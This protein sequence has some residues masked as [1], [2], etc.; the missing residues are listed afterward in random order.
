MS[1]RD[2]IDSTC[3]L[4]SIEVAFIELGTSVPAEELDRSIGQDKLEGRLG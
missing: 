4:K 1:W 3:C 2:K